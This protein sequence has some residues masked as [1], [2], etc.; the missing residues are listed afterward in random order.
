MLFRL[1]GLLLLCVLFL[2]MMLCM[3][4]S[5]L[6]LEMLLLKLLVMM[7]SCGLRGSLRCCTI[8]LRDCLRNLCLLFFLLACLCPFIPF[9]IAP[10]FLFTLSC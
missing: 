7:N 1:L 5:L 4:L 2:R 8:G 9:L 3:L 6:L 10:N